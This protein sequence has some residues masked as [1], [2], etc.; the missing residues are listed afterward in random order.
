MH[1]ASLMAQND[2]ASST[3]RMAD[4]IL[5]DAWGQSLDEYLKDATARGLSPERISRELAVGTGGL[6]SVSL[7]TVYRWMQHFGIERAAD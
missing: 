4:K 1:D 7:R 5:T 3:M 6:I 2:L